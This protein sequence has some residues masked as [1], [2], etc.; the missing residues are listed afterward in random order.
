MSRE[1]GL[2]GRPYSSFENI[3]LTGLFSV[4][5]LLLSL[6]LPHWLVTVETLPP[7]NLSPLHLL[8]LHIGLFSVCPQVNVTT[9]E[10]GV[11]CTSISYGDLEEVRSGLWLPVSRTARILTRMR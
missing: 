11:E 2:S 1:R 4:L 3:N 5:S 9:T 7:S 6:S 10:L 8:E